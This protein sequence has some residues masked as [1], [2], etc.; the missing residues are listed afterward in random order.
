MENQEQKVPKNP[1]NAASNAKEKP[2][3]G[4]I[5]LMVW[6]AWS[7]LSALLA[8]KGSQLC[9]PLMLT[10]LGSILQS[11]VL[12]GLHT[13][14][15]LGILKKKIWGWKFI[16]GMEIFTFLLGVASVIVV[17]MDTENKYINFIMTEQMSK[18]NDPNVSNM[19]ESMK[20]MMK[21]GIFG[22]VIFAGILG[23]IVCI[24]VFR[25][26]KYFDKV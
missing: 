1:Q 25:K 18:M 13:T 8:A 19:M 2:P 4:M 3:V 21:Y 17:F 23:L 5:V 26:R 16:I 22:G 14:A 24:Y 10:G 6:F 15:F 12:A 20:P 9:G 11:S 7:S